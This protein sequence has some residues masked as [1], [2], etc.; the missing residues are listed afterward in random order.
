MLKRYCVRLNTR[1]SPLPCVTFVGVSQSLILLKQQRF[2]GFCLVVEGKVRN[3]KDIKFVV[4][5]FGIDMFASSEYENFP[6]ELILSVF[7]ANK[8]NLNHII[9]L[10]KNDLGSEF[11]AFLS[12]LGSQI[13]GC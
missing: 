6:L 1:Y 12:F 7:V 2:C 13:E 11:Y 3:R 8:L 10:T 5:L 4:A 9:L